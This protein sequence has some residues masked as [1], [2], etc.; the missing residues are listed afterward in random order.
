MSRQD[1]YNEHDAYK[2]LKNKTTTS[3]TSHTS[4]NTSRTSHNTSYTSDPR[5]ESQY[6]SQYNSN[7]TPHYSSNTP[8]N[9]QSKS[10]SQKSTNSHYSSHTSQKPSTNTKPQTQPQSTTSQ[11]TQK[12][13]PSNTQVPIK[14]KLNKMVPNLN[15]NIESSQQKSIENRSNGSDDYKIVALNAKV[16]KSKNEDRAV[17]EN[18]TKSVKISNNVSKRKSVNGGGNKSTED[19]TNLSE[20][21]GEK[22]FS[23]LDEYRMLHFRPKDNFEKLS[24]SK[25]DEISKDQNEVDQRLLGYLEI[26]E[27]EYRC[28]QPGTYIRY[29]KEGTLYRAGGVLKLNRWP[30]YW[31]LE[32]IDG[33]KIKWSVPLQN[34]KSIYYMRDK[35]EIQRHQRNRERLYE[36]VLKEKF[37]VLDRDEYIK[38]RKLYDNAADEED[39]SRSYYTDDDS[40]VNIDVKF[41]KK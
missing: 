34:T 17:Y 3:H 35:E 8:S 24:H 5:Y 22:D 10:S 14:S 39:E 37:V 32:S 29:L 30:K 21:G 23:E 4:H 25:Q 19:T 18:E 28:I 11:K 6:T 41:Q 13:T 12:Q 15:V 9:T 40:S 38:M 26:P 2:M 31:V 27:E 7:S 33:K 16:G 20:G 36:G 1:K